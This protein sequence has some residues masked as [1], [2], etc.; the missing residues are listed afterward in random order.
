MRFSGLFLALS[1]S[2]SLSMYHF[3]MRWVWGFCIRDIVVLANVLRSCNENINATHWALGVWHLL[4]INEQFT[5]FLIGAFL[6]IYAKFTI[7]FASRQKFLPNWTEFI[8]RHDCAGWRGL[9]LMVGLEWQNLMYDI[10]MFKSKRENQNLLR[11]ADS[12]GS[13]SIWPS[14]MAFTTGITIKCG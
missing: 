5:C 9:V 2:R 8:E 7:N 1:L 10:K 12:L 13:Y 6:G 3:S 14:L 11:H 4:Y